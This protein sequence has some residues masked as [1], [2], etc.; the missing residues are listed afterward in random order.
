MKFFRFKGFTFRPHRQLTAEE[1]RTSGTNSAWRRV[2]VQAPVEES[3]G[4]AVLEPVLADRDSGWDYKAFY[5]AA[6][7]AGA[8]KID[9]FL[10]A[11]RGGVLF[12]PSQRYLFAL[13][14]QV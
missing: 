5:Q 6:K 14:D 3:A 2:R 9:L 4:A 10:V 12:L 7:Q 11:G 8:A 13:P 1:K